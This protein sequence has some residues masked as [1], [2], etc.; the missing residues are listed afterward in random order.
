MRPITRAFLAGSLALLAFL[1]FVTY[2]VLQAQ[3]FGPSEGAFT[4]PAAIGALLIA[5]VV[6]AA[7]GA[8]TGRLPPLWFA[9]GALLGISYALGFSIGALM[10]PVALLLMAF[11]AAM[12]DEASGRRATAP[13]LAAA[14][15]GIT[16]ALTL[17][18]VANRLSVSPSG[19]AAPGLPEAQWGVTLAALLAAAA[20]ALASRG[21][22]WGPAA[23]SVGVLLLAWAGW[24]GAGGANA[25]GTFFAPT[26]VV[27]GLLLGLAALRTSGPRSAAEEATPA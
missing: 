17:V 8:K 14:A 6:V 21:A 15:T 27:A 3:R 5:S 1:L 10:L 23:A 7:W 4:I 19:E 2:F 26:L 12:K 16:G 11:V 13:A 22:R 9:A 18:L 24:S 20:L 25:H